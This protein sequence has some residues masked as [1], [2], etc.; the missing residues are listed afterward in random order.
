M[1]RTPTRIVV[2]LALAV[3]A[4]T[5][6]GIAAA[7]TLP[8]APAATDDAITWSV[9]PLQTAD[10]LR[11]SFEYTVDPGTQIVDSVV[12]TNQ[13]TTSAEFLIYATDAINEAE[14]GA[15]SL[16]KRE[17]APTD[18]GAW[19]TTASEKVTIEPG[20]QAVIPFNLLVPSDATPGDHVAGI[21]ASV[22]TSGETDGAAVVLEQRVGARV[23]LNVTGPV[24]SGVELSGVTSGY[25][26]ELNPFAPGEV[27][28]SYDVRNTG[29][30][31]LD[32]RQKLQITGPFG[33]PLGEVTPDPITELL[34]RQS[35]RVHA[36]VPAVTAL[37]LAWSTVTAVPGDI[38]SATIPLEEE[39]ELTGPA[40]PTVA[41]SA[42]PS[43]SAAPT[44]TPTESATPTPTS[45]SDAITDVVTDGDA[46]EF[47][48]V[49]STVTSV[50]ISW[51]MLALIVFALVLVYFIWS[52]VAG[53]RERMYLAIDEAAAAAREEALAA[54]DE[55]PNQ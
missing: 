39:E 12:V 40:A 44:S 19:I 31:R 26:A 32:V 13:G 50:A 5:P 53:T 23:Y 35:I 45:T 41:P 47:V 14:T 29:N 27:S 42:D 6:A 22:L 38:G 54:T 17:E 34:P 9:E 28:V 37:L 21:V 10:G 18:S 46:L 24:E 20:M 49:T 1:T 15:F 3:L 16:L 55:K 11:R 51:T 52:Y 36:D 33:I 48:P 4:F 30:V 7:G 43:G 2:A 25:T 8:S